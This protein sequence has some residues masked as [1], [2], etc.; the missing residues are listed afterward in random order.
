MLHVKLNRNEAEN[1]IQ[2]NILIHPRPPDGAKT[3][4]SE[5]GHV[6]YQIKKERLVEYYAIL[7]YAYP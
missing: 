4:F 2:A 6:A 1:A 7:P 3:F 5:E